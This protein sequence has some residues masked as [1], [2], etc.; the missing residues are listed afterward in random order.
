MLNTVM[1]ILAGVLTFLVL[2]YFL[3]AVMGCSSEA[4]G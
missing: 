4:L 3:L 2:G 1:R